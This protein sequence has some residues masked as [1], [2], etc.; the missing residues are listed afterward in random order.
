V[1]D[2]YQPQEGLVAVLVRNWRPRRVA[3]QPSA[4]ASG[5][6]EHSAPQSRV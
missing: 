1:H 6:T 5:R 4:T 3:V 2:S